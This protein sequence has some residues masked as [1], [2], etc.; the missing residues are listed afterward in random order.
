MLRFNEK[1]NLFEKKVQIF[2]AVAADRDA[3]LLALVRICLK[4]LLE[5]ARLQT[6]AGH[7]YRQLQLDLHYLALTLRPLASKDAPLDTPSF[8]YLRN[9]VVCTLQSNYLRCVDILQS[10]QSHAGRHT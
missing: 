10:V 4:S 9:V 8:F 3:I 6:F 7:G 5:C 1:G 2:G